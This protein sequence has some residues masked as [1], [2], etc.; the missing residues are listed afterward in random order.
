MKS[1]LF[2]IS[3]FL[4]FFSGI[5]QAGE[6][7]GIQMPDKIQAAGQELVLNGMALRKK[8]F[9]KVYVA[10]LYLPSKQSSAEA[11]LNA[12]T[13]RSLSMHFV[14]SVGGEKICGA[15]KEGLAANTP[16]ASTDLKAKFDQLCQWMS[17]A[18]NGD[19][20]IFRYIP[21]TG[22]EVWFKSAKKGTIESKDFADALYRCWIGQK[23]GPGEEFKQGLLG[24]SS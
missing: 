19:E 15:W 23:P 9:I 18:K 24:K 8:A 22:T 14:R 6:L 2:S 21:G 12:D 20:Y 11:I 7:N 3:I 13:A 5:A 4:F 1:R 10:G 17:D 16:N